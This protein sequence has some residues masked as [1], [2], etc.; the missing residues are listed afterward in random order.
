MIK[1]LEL[2]LWYSITLICGFL[3]IFYILQY[4]KREKLSKSS[5]FGLSI[6]LVCFGIAQLHENIRR[7]TIGTYDDI[8]DAWSIGT[9]IT[10]INLWLRILFEIF[11]WIAIAN[12]HFNI[13]KYI[14]KKTKYIMVICSLVEGAV[15]ISLYFYFNLFVFWALVINFFF[16]GYSIPVLFLNFSREFKGNYVMRRG[17]IVIALGMILFVTGV[18]VDLPE[19]AYFFILLGQPVPE[20]FI[21]IPSPVL[22][23]LGLLVLSLGYKSIFPK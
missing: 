23:I 9:Q 2:I 3:S 22:V 18:M 21:R 19:S 5:F 4:R 14:F 13:E 1:I 12:L 15:A 8:I 20:V 7:Y 11:A 6:F 17:C 10:G 16:V